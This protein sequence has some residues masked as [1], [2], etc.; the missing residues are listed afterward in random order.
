MKIVNKTQCKV[1]G[2]L[3]IAE[4]FM[5]PERD[6]TFIAIE[7]CRSDYSGAFCNAI[8]LETGCIVCFDDDEEVVPVSATLTIE[9][10]RS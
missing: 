6:T 10:E 5:N 1:F 4:V 7:D 2:D 8:D 3:S 9:S